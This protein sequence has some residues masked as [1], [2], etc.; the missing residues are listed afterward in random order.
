MTTS[1]SKPST[2]SAER[3][4][5]ALVL[6]TH[7]LEGG[8]ADTAQVVASLARLLEHLGRQTLPLTAL[9]ELVVT[10]R[11]LDLARRESLRTQTGD[12]VLLRFVELPAGTSYYQAKN[13]GFA[14]SAAEVV[15]FGDSDC[16]PADTWLEELVRPLVDDPALGVVAG[17]TCYRP[18]S[19][20]AAATSI[21][22]MYFT[23]P[24]GDGCTRNFYA[25]NVAFRRSV[26]AEHPF[27]ERQ[28]VYRGHCQLLGAEL[29][30]AG[31]RVRFAKGAV[32]VHRFP[33]DLSELLELR[34]LRG[35]DAAE[36]APTFVRSYA[37]G[38]ARGLERS[39]L[40]ATLAV[41]GVRLTSSLRWLTH[42]HSA[43][44][45]RRRPSLLLSVAGMGLI[46]A[47]DATAAVGRVLGLEAATRRLRAG[48]T[49]LAYHRNGD[50]LTG[51]GAA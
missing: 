25:N 43:G 16:W 32:T 10:H 49:V 39:P 33:D 5:L 36:L 17:R 26:F 11:G 12:A 34:R 19:F 35:A 15:I 8:G 6:E 29:E 51:G 23:S 21:D 2:T 3:P 48:S 28:G 45:G 37:P 47:V 18:G 42:E 20:G 14:H 40:A 41:L 9:A 50:R 30:Q 24:L 22:F 46:S 13:M 4:S 38:W 1:M 44:R 7:N 27:P 31:V